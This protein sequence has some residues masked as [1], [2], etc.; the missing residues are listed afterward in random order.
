MRR[1]EGLTAN[2][3]LADIYEELVAQGRVTERI[4]TAIERLV[5]MLEEER[6]NG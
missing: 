3:Q 6:E 5:T 2:D 4:A 1:T